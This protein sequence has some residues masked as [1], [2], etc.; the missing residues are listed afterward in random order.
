ML[1]NKWF[2]FGPGFD[3]CGAAERFMV[4]RKAMDL[5][6]AMLRLYKNLPGHDLDNFLANMAVFWLVSEEAEKV[7][8]REEKQMGSLGKKAKKWLDSL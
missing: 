4:S 1:Q 8:V 2:D 6:K 7:V 3:I 5:E